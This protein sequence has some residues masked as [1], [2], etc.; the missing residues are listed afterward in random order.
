MSPFVRLAIRYNI[1]YN[2]YIK[3]GAIMNKVLISI[4]EQLAARMRVAIPTRQRSKVIAQL[5]E[6]EVERREQILYECAV[7][8]EEDSDLNKEME[9]WNITL[10]DGL[11][12]ESW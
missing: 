1:Y 6:K 3:L 9:D 5:I 4:P 2:V 10:Q 8:L 7:A 11:D 12:D